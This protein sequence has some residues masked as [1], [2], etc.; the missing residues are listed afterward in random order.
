MDGWMDGYTYVITRLTVLTY[1]GYY[2]N[3][4]LREVFKTL[5]ERIILPVP[6]GGCSVEVES[7][8]I[9]QAGISP[10]LGFYHHEKTMKKR[11][12]SQNSWIW[13]GLKKWYTP[14]LQCSWKWWLSSGW[15]GVLEFQ[16]RPRPSPKS[17]EIGGIKHLQMVGWLLLGLPHYLW[18]FSILEHPLNQ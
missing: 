1:Q 14:K 9:W 15:N 16:R 10:F 18:F 6:R 17:P 5:V 13:V 11:C 7:Q 2:C 3:Q 4:F 12:L 8:W